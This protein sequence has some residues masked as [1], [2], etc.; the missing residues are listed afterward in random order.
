M[1]QTTLGGSGALLVFEKIGNRRVNITNVITK[2]QIT[3]NG[4]IRD[5]NKM[6]FI[7]ILL[8]P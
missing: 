4:N 8:I 1:A 6:F 2:D 5:I 3:T 7:L